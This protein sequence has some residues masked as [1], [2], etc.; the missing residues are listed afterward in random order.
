MDEDK[1]IKFILNPPSVIRD[2]YNSTHVGA[3]LGIIEI[4]K[5]IPRFRVI[6]R[7]IFFHARPACNYLR[8]NCFVRLSGRLSSLVSWPIVSKML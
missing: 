1:V 6:C 2:H 7:V 8:E 3:I 4:D 5:K